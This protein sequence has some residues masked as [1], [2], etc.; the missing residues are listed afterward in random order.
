MRQGMRVV[1]SRA[2]VGLVLAGDGRARE[3]TFAFSVDPD[4]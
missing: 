1:A 4:R 2:A 3:G